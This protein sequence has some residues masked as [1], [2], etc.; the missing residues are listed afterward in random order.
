MRKMLLLARHEI[1]TRLRQPGFL[2]I[3]LVLPL[4]SVLVLL[5]VDLLG[6]SMPQ[7][8]PAAAEE[9]LGVGD[10]SGGIGY[11]NETSLSIHP[12]AE[13]LTREFRAFAD[14]AAAA[15]ALEA[16][17][18]E[19]YYL[20]PPDYVEHGEIVRVAAD[21][22]SLP[23]DTLEIEMLLSA[24]L[25][26]SSDPRLAARA[27]EPLTLETVGLEG[28]APRADLSSLDAAQ[29]AVPLLFAMLLYMSIGTSSG[30][31]LNSMISEKENR[32]LEMLLTSLHPWHLLGGKVLGVGALGLLQFAVWLGVGALWY[33]QGSAALG[34][35]AAFELSPALWALALLYFLLG[36]LVYASLMAGVGAV[37]TST[38]EGALWTFWLFLPVMLPL[39]LLLAIIDRPDGL[40][41]TVLSLVPFTAPL[42]M[43]IRLT[44]TEVSAGQVGLSLLLLTGAVGLCVW[45]AARLFR[46]TVLMTGKALSPLAVL[47]ALRG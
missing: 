19:A 34:E 7:G 12:P 17:E 14:E 13:T 23:L 18:I 15:A 26:H 6:N 46:A 37:V 30:L 29:F 44:L 25:L 10:E 24:S 39:L 2:I 42:T 4:A 38:R 33:G 41:S 28:A 1:V 27:Y 8:T 3:T 5:A 43:V 45:G 20:L 47:R 32:V 31:L 35:A 36:Y 21:E 11:V 40:L 16:D 22:Q 9:W